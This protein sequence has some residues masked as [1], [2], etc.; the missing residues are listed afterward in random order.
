MNGA[1]MFWRI[2]LWWKSLW[3]RRDEF[4]SSFDLD[5]D[6]NAGSLLVSDAWIAYWSDV[7]RFLLIG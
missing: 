3:I 5:L 4:H 1:I 7:E 6:A 2:K